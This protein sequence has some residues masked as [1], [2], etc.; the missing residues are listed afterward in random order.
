MS[1]TG[2]DLDH[3]KDFKFNPERIKKMQAGSEIII[4]FIN[5][6][7]S[8]GLLRSDLLST[9]NLTELSTR[10]IDTQIPT[11][12]RKVKGLIEMDL[13][14]Q[15]LQTYK[16]ELRWLGHIATYIKKFDQL[17][18]PAQLELWQVAGGTIAKELVL[19]NTPIQD[20]WTVKNIQITKE[21][22]LLTRK[23]W[24]L[25]HESGLWVYMLDFA[26]GNQ[27]LP[28]T[29]H[30]G[31]QV[32][33]L[34]FPYPGLTL[35]RILFKEL[36]L[37]PAP[38]VNNLNVFDSILA[39]KKFLANVYAHN[40]FIQEIPFTLIDMR[41]TMFSEGLIISDTSSDYISISA[42][43][44]KKYYKDINHHWEL[45]AESDDKNHFFNII[46]SKDQYYLIN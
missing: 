38:A 5:I 7:L 45:V 18:L 9:E 20:G 42:G 14:P 25:G 11:A 17:T 12:A 31:S 28:D 23:I 41:A 21:D 29:Y 10:L 27:K 3:W 8:Q 2:L 16:C 24:M 35:G 30:R 43:G 15:N 13:S 4:N 40:I 26:F 33:G 36:H 46:F 6:A 22:S 44:E 32:Y 34:A 37:K 39:L 1:L 19:K